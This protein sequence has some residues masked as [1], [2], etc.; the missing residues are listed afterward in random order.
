MLSVL[1]AKAVSN[2]NF[3]A[4]LSVKI[5]SFFSRSSNTVS[6][7]KIRCGVRGREGEASGS[8]DNFA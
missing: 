7:L 5:L 1:V 8:E 3:H 4:N 6:R 2:E